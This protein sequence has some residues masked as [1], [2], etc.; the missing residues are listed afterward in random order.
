[1]RQALARLQVDTGAPDSSLTAASSCWAQLL[2]PSCQ[3]ARP[4]LPPNKVSTKRLPAGKGSPTHSLLSTWD[5][6]FGAGD[7]DMLLLN[8]SS[9]VRLGSHLLSCHGWPDS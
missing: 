3:S 6:S 2:H 5:S 7:L 9:E 8:T 1:M 4:T